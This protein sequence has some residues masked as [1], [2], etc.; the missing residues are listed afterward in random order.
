M[1]E[2]LDGTVNTSDSDLDSDS[3][4]VSDTENTS[5]NG[6]EPG[7]SH[8]H[9]GVKVTHAQTSFFEAS[10]NINS[11]ESN[12]MNGSIR[13]RDFK[14]PQ[15]EGSVGR[16]TR[17]ASE[18]HLANMLLG[19]SDYGPSDDKH[20][21]YYAKYRKSSPNFMTLHMFT[22]QMNGN[23]PKYVPVYRRNSRGKLLKLRGIGPR[24]GEYKELSDLL[25]G[26][27]A[28]GLKI[29]EEP[30]TEV[31][32]QTLEPE[33]AVRPSLREEKGKVMIRGVPLNG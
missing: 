6:D 15:K 24:G 23:R 25:V 14:A 2:A 28:G 9:K 21:T 27:V 12:T 13:S 26:E 7:L 20:P 18:E 30:K 17:T 31:V 5:S 22:G 32:L 11:A 8:L 29:L 19:V 1:S 4:N 16:R 10:S 33:K 3:N